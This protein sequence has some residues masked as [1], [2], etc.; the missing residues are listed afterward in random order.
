LCGKAR[1]AQHLRPG[2]REKEASGLGDWLAARGLAPVGDGIAM[3][4]G[5][6]PAPASKFQSFALAA[7][8]LG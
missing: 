4:R 5:D 3:I 7:Q 8:A 1:T 2:P 6:A